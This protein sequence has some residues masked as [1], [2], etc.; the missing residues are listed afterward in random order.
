SSP[1]TFVFPPPV[2]VQ[3]G[4]VVDVPDHELF[5]E[6]FHARTVE[7]RAAS[8]LRILNA[9]VSALAWAV[10]IGAVREWTAWA[11]VFGRLAAATPGIGHDWGAVG[12]EVVGVSE[13]RRITRRV[14]VVAE[15]GGQRIAVMPAAVMTSML[16]SGAAHSGV[17]SHA[18]WLTRDA[19]EA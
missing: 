18:D 7:F 6:L 12:V 13:G 19:L 9:A 10:R 14:S 17:V 1:Q 11:G 2:G 15:S 5:P 16:L 4:Y 3:N 8:E